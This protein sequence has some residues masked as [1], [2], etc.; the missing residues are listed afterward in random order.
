MK[1]KFLLKNISLYGDGLKI[2]EIAKYN[3]LL[4]GY[5]FNPTLFRQLKVENYLEFSMKILNF[6]KKNQFLWR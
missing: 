1:S 4:S 5:T 3:K 2:D 6:T